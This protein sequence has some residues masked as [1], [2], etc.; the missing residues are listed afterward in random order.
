MDLS[1]LGETDDFISKN[2][3]RDDVISRLLPKIFGVVGERGHPRH[4]QRGCSAELD[5]ELA[6]SGGMLGEDRI[7]LS[8][9]WPVKSQIVKVF[10]A[11][12]I[13]T[14]SRGDPS[15]YRYWSGHLGLMSWRRGA[16]EDAVMAYPSVPLSLADTFLRGVFRTENQLVH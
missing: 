12:I 8:A 9:Y 10:S 4:N 11:H 16:W 3:N 14:P 5:G 6:L 1:S 13:S 7:V 2:R 15:F